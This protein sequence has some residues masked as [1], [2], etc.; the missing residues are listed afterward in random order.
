[1][2]AGSPAAYWADMLMLR[3]ESHPHTWDLLTVADTIG[4]I[5]GMH[6]K[7]RFMLPRPVQLYPAIMPMMMTAR[8]PS[9]P[10][11]H[12]L[13]SH[14]VGGCAKLVMPESMHAFI[15]MLADRIGGNREIA[16][17]HYR[18]DTAASVDLA[19]DVI[20]IICRGA[21]VKEMISGAT[22]EWAGLAT[23]LVPVKPPPGPVS[24]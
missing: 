18:S 4:Q 23:G 1:M 20:E 17:L 16:G 10:N 21:L 2:Q 13:Q 7:L 3:R 5:V 11:A 15:T 12:A 22:A 8:H 9:Y 24:T 14:L 6:F 19:P